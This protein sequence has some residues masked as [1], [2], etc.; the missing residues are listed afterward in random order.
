MPLAVTKGRR[1]YDITWKHMATAMTLLKKIKFLAY[2][3][4]FE[5]VGINRRSK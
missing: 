5:V 3:K 2:A 4:E 1:E